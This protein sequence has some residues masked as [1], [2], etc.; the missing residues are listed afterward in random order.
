M[1]GED[2][3]TED[4]SHSAVTN[5][6][7]TKELLRAKRSLELQEEIQSHNV[8]PVRKTK[9]LFESGIFDFCFQL[10]KNSKN[11]SKDQGKL[12]FNILMPILKL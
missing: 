2:G 10:S 5:M 11:P 3:S 9:E 1:D 7:N 4:N 6:K 12:R 8:V